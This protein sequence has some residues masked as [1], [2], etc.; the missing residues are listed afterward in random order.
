MSPRKEIMEEEIVCNRERDLA[1][2]RITIT[3][4]KISSSSFVISFLG[5]SLL[6]R[7]GSDK[8]LVI[9]NAGLRGDLLREDSSHHLLIRPMTTIKLIIPWA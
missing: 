2:E 6:I 9:S 7:H 4:I 1:D 8:S 5:M 3:N